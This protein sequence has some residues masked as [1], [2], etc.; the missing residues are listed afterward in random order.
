MKDT[1]DYSYDYAHFDDD[2]S[3]GGGFLMGALAGAALASTLVWL[4]DPQSGAQR[5]AFVRDRASSAYRRSREGAS[6]ARD[7]AR[8]IAD[9]GRSK[10]RE[11]RGAAGRMRNDVRDEIEGTMREAQGSG[12]AQ[13]FTRSRGLGGAEGFGGAQ[14][15][16][17][18]TGAAGLGLAGWG[19]ARRGPLGLALGALG[20]YLA[21]TSARQRAGSRLGSGIQIE[22]GVTVNAPIERVWTHVR[23]VEAWPEFMSHVREIVPTGERRYHWRVDGPAGVEAEWDAEITEERPNERLAWCTLPGSMVDSEG[24][25]DLENDGRGGTRVQ[26]RMLYDPPA[27]AAGHVVAK[28]F[29]R[30]PVRQARDD[31]QNLKRAIESGASGGATDIGGSAAGS[32]A[33]GGATTSTH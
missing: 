17:I 6:V 18:A 1:D 25:I 13:G 23:R 24:S 29:R 2:E 7:R 11:V 27:G 21:A 4:L 20:V 8:T 5:R 3:S 16:R 9:Q 19:L 32:S 28:L 10:L 14:G 30:D 31:L 26:L 15:S 33:L 12:I 22:T